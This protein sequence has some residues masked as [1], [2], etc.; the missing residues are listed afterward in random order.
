VRHLTDGSRV[1]TLWLRLVSLRRR[2]PYEG[3]AGAQGRRYRPGVRCVGGAVSRAPGSGRPGRCGRTFADSPRGTR[4]GCEGQVPK[5][6]APTSSA[7]PRDHR[8][9]GE[10]PRCPASLP[11]R[12]PAAAGYPCALIERR[13]AIREAIQ[14]RQRVLAERLLSD[15]GGSVV[16]A[17]PDVGRFLRPEMPHGATEV[18]IVLV[19]P[20]GTWRVGARHLRHVDPEV[21]AE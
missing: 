4:H 11:V 17:P 15:G 10:R 2:C 16:Q 8:R 19:D 18:T 7:P 13:G 5:R 20:V 12:A 14:P 3:V 9:P 1:H 6:T 21:K